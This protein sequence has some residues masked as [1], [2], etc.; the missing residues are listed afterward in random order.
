MI[1]AWEWNEYLLLVRISFRGGS[2]TNFLVAH[3]TQEDVIEH[4]IRV[5]QAT[6]DISMIEAT[7]LTDESFDLLATHYRAVGTGDRI[8]GED[9]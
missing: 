7:P 1:R 6:R 9:D 5:W 2:S 8:L 4:C 3:M